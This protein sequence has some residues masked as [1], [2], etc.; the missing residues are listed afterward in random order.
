MSFKHLILISVLAVALAGCVQDG[1]TQQQNATASAEPTAT[2]TSAE[3]ELLKYPEL[4]AFIKTY[5]EGF[6]VGEQSKRPDYLPGVVFSK[7]PPMPKDFYTVK[8]LV[9][10]GIFTD[11]KKIGEAYWKQPE[12]YPN[13]ES[14][15]VPLYQ[16]PPVDRW[17]AFGLGSYPSEILVLSPRNNEFE[18]NF[19][20]YTSW[21]VQT[22]QGT[23][24]YYD[25]PAHGETLLSE[26]PD[27]TR[28]ITQDPE[29]ARR[30]FEVE[31]VPEDVLLEPV[32]PVFEN[33]WVQKVRVK[34]KVRDAPPGR[35]YIAIGGQS[36]SQ[37]LAQEWL[38]KYKTRYTDAAN[39][40]GGTGRPWEA[41]YIEIQ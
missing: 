30:H 6:V 37:E 35:Y 39:N 3:Q 20:M 14:Q 21:L 11:M 18:I 7:L 19:F 8:L 22:Y 33:G 26:F 29:K 25:F 23:R 31:L 34:V 9:E 27:G 41:I 40:F 24:L 28:N 17:A 16:K 10:K 12:F 15:G 5:Q 1:T 36:P 38:W 4:A 2:L 32:F 13:F